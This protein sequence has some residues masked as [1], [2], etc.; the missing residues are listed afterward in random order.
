MKVS[1]VF[2]EMLFLL[3]CKFGEVDILVFCDVKRIKKSI[4]VVYL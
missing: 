1:E 4:L 2:Y 3:C